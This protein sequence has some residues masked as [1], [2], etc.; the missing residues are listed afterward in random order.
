MDDMPRLGLFATF[1]VASACGTS[2]RRAVQNAASAPAP[3]HVATLAPSPRPAP[4]NPWDGS[5]AV[6]N[7]GLTE[8][9]AC[10]ATEDC[11]KY[12][13]ECVARPFCRAGTC[14]F[15]F[16]YGRVCTFGTGDSAQSGVCE[17][18][19]CLPASER[20][21]VCG[22]AVAQYKAHAGEHDGLA[23]GRGCADQ[24]CLERERRYFETEAPKAGEYLIKCLAGDNQTGA[25]GI[26]WSPTAPYARPFPG[27]PPRSKPQPPPALPATGSP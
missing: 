21:R 6:P 24:D 14:V 16:G 26:E 22:S 9:P 12:S 2:P 18:A 15:S 25:P 4:L 1:A 17:A 27:L 20:P 7:T 13:N 5:R 19:R 8:G 11:V 23:Y 10:S 3:E